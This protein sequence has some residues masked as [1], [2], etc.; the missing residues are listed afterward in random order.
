MVYRTIRFTGDSP[1]GGLLQGIEYPI[2]VIDGVSVIVDD[3]GRYHE[4]DKIG[5][6]QLMEA[7]Q[8]IY[9]IKIVDD[10]TGERFV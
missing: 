9:G 5:G 8:P 7:Y 4:E 2:I 1:G 10:K 6:W 3:D